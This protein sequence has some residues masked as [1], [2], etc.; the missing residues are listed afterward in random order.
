MGA[1]C[2]F[3]RE[4]DLE[5]AIEEGAGRPGEHKGT[6]TRGFNSFGLVEAACSGQL[7][8]EPRQGTFL[9]F[10]PEILWLLGMPRR[11]RGARVSPWSSWPAFSLLHPFSHS[12][13]SCP[14][15]APF[16]HPRALRMLVLLCLLDLL[17]VWLLV[18]FGRRKIAV[19]ESDILNSAQGFLKLERPQRNFRM[20][21]C[22]SR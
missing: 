6:S 21:L 20:S 11:G 4:M 1:P 22:L 2:Q 15:L 18:Q 17:T 5:G 14:V 10:L 12:L 13:K 7:H 9:A 19:A 8:L 16:C 3:E